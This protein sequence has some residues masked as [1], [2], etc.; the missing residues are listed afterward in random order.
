MLEKDQ[1]FGFLSWPQ[2]AAEIQKGPLKQ[3]L[4]PYIV[5]NINPASPTSQMDLFSS[6]LFAQ[7]DKLENPAIIHLL[8]LALGGIKALI[9]HTIPFCC[10]LISLTIPRCW[11]KMNMNLYTWI[12]FRCLYVHK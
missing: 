2:K 8:S 5:F 7:S 3:T 12:F 10:N 6:R 1:G 9:H 11:M 4:K